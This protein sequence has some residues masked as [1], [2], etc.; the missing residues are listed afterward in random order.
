[1]DNDQIFNLTILIIEN[2]EI[3]IND[4]FKNSELV[5]ELNL[6]IKVP[7]NLL[8]RGAPILNLAFGGVNGL[9]LKLK[10][11]ENELKIYNLNYGDSKKGIFQVNI[12]QINIKKAKEVYKTLNE[13]IVDKFSFKDVF[14]YEI[15][16]TMT[17][18]FDGYQKYNKKLKTIK[19]PKM[20]SIKIINGNINEN[21]DLRKQYINEIDVEQNT[22]NPGKSIVHAV[23]R[24]KEFDENA[25]EYILSDITS[26][27]NIEK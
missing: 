11:L 14:A 17:V 23:Y 27:I 4:L 15:N 6:D 26:I 12:P 7:E 18:D 5:E 3:N 2:K 19:N 22:D 20:R 25:I 24:K 16:I 21:E 9:N 8:G 10:N 1:M 13:I